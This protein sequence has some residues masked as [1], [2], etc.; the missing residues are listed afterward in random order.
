MAYSALFHYCVMK[1]K[2]LLIGALLFGTIAMAQIGIG[3]TNP[4]PSSILELSSSTKGFLPPRMTNAEYNAINQPAE[5]LVI[6]CTDCTKKGLLIYNGIS[7]SPLVYTLPPYNSVLPVIS[8][9]PTNFLTTDTNIQFSCSVPVFVGANSISY[10]WF[11]NNTP[12]PGATSTSYVHQNLSNDNTFYCAVTATNTYGSTTVNSNSIVVSNTISNSSPPVVTY[13][14]GIATVTNGTW[15]NTNLSFSY[16]WQKNG[17]NISGATT[18]TF[19]PNQQELWGILTCVVTGFDALNSGTATSNPVYPQGY[20]KMEFTKA[21][22]TFSAIHSD[23]FLGTQLDLNKWKTSFNTWQGRGARFTP[24]NVS[25]QNG[26]LQLKSSVLNTTKLQE[27]YTRINFLHT[28]STT[29]V[30]I[31][32]WSAFNYPTWNNNAINT[33]LNNLNNLGMD[34]IGAAAVLSKNADAARGYY[35]VRIKT[36]AIALSSAFWFTGNGSE[37]DVTES[38]GG[39]AI[40]DVNYQNT[41]PYKIYANGWDTTAW[42]CLCGIPPY[43]APVKLY[44]QYFVLGFLWDTTEMKV[45]YNDQLVITTPLNMNPSINPSI[46]TSLKNIIFDTELLR[47]YLGWPSY[48]DLT[49]PTKNTFYVDWIRVWNP[50]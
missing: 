38:Q 9:T 42:T 46:F 29:P 12:V 19:T 22:Y 33:D 30:D 20:D 34:A 27:L 25:V 13:T 21:G 37:L 14:N 3:T 48:S 1:S 40:N 4:A 23:E 43:T 36:S 49:D 11:Y 18:S 2:A 24:S 50:N 16:Q 15:V 26:T 5:G 7:W 28:G 6:Y 8:S 35:E 39:V 41:I 10:Q 32:T 17:V 45:Y 31:N 44:E 47:P